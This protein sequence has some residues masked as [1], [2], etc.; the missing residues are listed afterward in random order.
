MEERIQKLMA[1]AGLAS[2]RKAEELIAQGVV[3]VNGKVAHL[4]DKADPATD[5]IRV[6]GT[7][8]KISDARIYVMIN[9]PLNIVS[10]VSAQEQESRRTVRD[11]VPL[12]GHLYPVGRLDADSEGLVLMTSDG[13]L[14]QKLTHPRYEHPKV[15]EVTVNGQITD[16]ALDIW[17][18]G[19][20]LEEDGLTRPVEIKLLARDSASSF[21]R[22][23]MHEGKKRQIRRIG[24]V[25]GHPIKRLVRTQLGTLKLGSL[26]T[27]EWRH[28]T[29]EEI[30]ELRKSAGT[31]A[32][33][34]SRKLS[35]KKSSNMA[36]SDDSTNRKRSRPDQG[37]SPGGRR[38]TIR[39]SSRR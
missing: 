12:E 34:V 26:R 38:R 3:T 16:E 9:K 28:L 10:A 36:K 11:L 39:R 35:P 1:Q 18:R 23:T 31:P 37:R 8:L 17:R 32:R 6:D 15:Y 27:G 4:G 13:D 7:R 29:D 2:R 14:A 20:V 21:I 22:I 24:N 25:L 33:A 30:E 5:D 19:V